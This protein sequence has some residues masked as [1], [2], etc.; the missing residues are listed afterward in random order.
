MRPFGVDVP[1]APVARWM[2]GT[3]LAFQALPSDQGV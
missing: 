3:I 1:L 2:A